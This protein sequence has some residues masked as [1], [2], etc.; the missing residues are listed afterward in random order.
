MSDLTGESSECSTALA[1]AA[2]RHLA[3]VFVRDCSEWGLSIN[4]IN[5]DEALVRRKSVALMVP[6]GIV[7]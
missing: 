2:I 7:S 1:G 3:G 6:A 4:D 5:A